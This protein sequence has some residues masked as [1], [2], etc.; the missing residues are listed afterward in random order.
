LHDLVLDQQAQL[1]ALGFAPFKEELIR[2]YP[3]RDGLILFE[4]QLLHEGMREA[5]LHGQTVI[6]VKSQ[7]LFD[8]IP[9]LKD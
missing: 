7:Q 4:V 2:V 6:R 3:L 9:G 8:H 1:L 5:L